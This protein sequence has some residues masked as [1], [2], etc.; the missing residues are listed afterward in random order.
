M[1]T[2]F[3]ILNTIMEDKKEPIGNVNIIDDPIKII[4]IK[5]YNYF[6]YIEPKSFCFHKGTDEENEKYNKNNYNLLFLLFLLDHL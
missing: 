4:K 5:D 1:N 6:E 3:N 2:Y